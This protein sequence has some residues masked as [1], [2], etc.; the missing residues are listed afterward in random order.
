MRRHPG[1]APK[2]SARL[3]PQLES[4]RALIILHDRRSFV[5][6]V[7]SDGAGALLSPDARLRVCDVDGCRLY[8]PRPRMWS[9]GSVKEVRWLTGPEQEALAA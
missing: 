7:T 4:G 5:G 9:I 6:H 2:G 8:A 3:L 1:P